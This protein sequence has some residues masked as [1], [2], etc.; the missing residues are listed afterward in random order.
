MST[1]QHK[2]KEPN[3]I[4]KATE[5]VWVDKNDSVFLVYFQRVIWII[6]AIIIIASLFFWENIFMNLSLHAR[7]VLVGGV[8]YAI[9][10]GGGT[11]RKP[12]EFEIRFYDDYLVLYRERI[13]YDKTLEKKSIK[14]MYYKDIK[15]FVY[16]VNSHRINF[17]GIVEGIEW[18]YKK[19]GQL[20]E[21]PFYH[22]T[23]D[24]LCYFY[25]TLSNV[26]FVKEIETHS[27][28]R[29]EIRHT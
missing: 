26:D 1:E 28:L 2:E 7:I 21:K 23:T 22:K 17:Y 16:R 29:V 18:K 5:A 15:R 20:S 27:P 11:V 13:S 6:V 19:N 12:S 25:T 8:G 24:S 9:F 4:L 14:K 3:Y 10:G